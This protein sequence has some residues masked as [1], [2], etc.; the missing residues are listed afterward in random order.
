M[1]DTIKTKKQLIDE[2]KKLRRK[3]SHL[4]KLKVKDR[5]EEKA[6]SESEEKYR[7]TF[8]STGTATVIAEED[9]TLS[10][11]NSE[12]E[13]LCGYSREKIEGKKSWIEFVVKEDL[14]RMK[15]YHRQ[16]RTEEGAAPTN[17]EFRFVDRHGNIKE[18]FLT[19]A[20]IP[21]T[22][23]SVVS[24]LD[25]TERKLMEKTLNERV[26]ELNCLYGISGLTEKPD[27]S[28]EKIVQGTVDL[29]PPSWQY[30]DITC[31]RII[32]EGK[33]YTTE[34][35]RETEW[36]QTADVTTH[37]RRAGTVE[38]YYLEERP[39]SDEGPFLK[40][41][42]NLLYEIAERLG[43]IA[44]R[45]RAEGALRESEE[46]YR[47]LQANIPVGIFRTTADPEG[48]LLSV[49]PALARMFGYDN[50]EAMSETRVADLY[51]NHDDRKKFVEAVSSGG[52]ISN[53]EVQFKRNDGTP[54]WGSLNARAITDGSGKV[55]YF[56]GVL[57]DITEHKRAE[58]ALRKEKEKAQSYLDI[59]GVM[60]VVIGS[61]QK[62]SLINKRGGEILRYSEEDIVGKNWF[63]NFLPERIREDIKARFDVLMAGEKE[64]DPYFENP[65]LTKDGEERIILWH[66][67][68]LTDD[69][70]KII[71]TLSSGE[72][73][74]ERKQYF[75]DLNEYSKALE[76][77]LKERSEF[78]S[79]ASHELR[80]P[81][82][83]VNGYLDIIERNLENMDNAQ[84]HETLKKVMEHSERLTLLVETL[85]DISKIDDPK[86]TLPSELCKIEPIVKRALN[87]CE[88]QAQEKQIT[89]HF[90]GFD[91][92]GGKPCVIGDA[93]AIENVLL[94]ILGN[95]IKYSNE[96]SE[97][98][99]RCDT[100]DDTLRIDCIDQGIGL[101]PG[102]E[103]RIFEE[104]YRV[105]QG[106][107][108]KKSGHGLGLS[109]AR[110]LV[111]RM[112][113]RIWAHS[114]GLNKGTTVSFT[115]PLAKSE[116]LTEKE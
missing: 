54:F 44:E 84:I 63:D 11:V 89:C 17:Y 51:M 88:H 61:D 105:E 5:K 100:E 112:G 39:Q 77:L 52:A 23:K 95:A 109:I 96:G 82:T 47:S 38:V 59:A 69:S 50:P 104:F 65:I 101:P 79:M 30:P 114:E 115:L 36:V 4:E 34:N 64:S 103:E 102:V 56:D 27:I 68:I 32:I 97:V 99:I 41:A 13:R 43:K 1:D 19:I 14:E 6:F 26:K 15:E 25:I 94:N 98:I 110:R 67:T 71:G 76:S 18:I 53:Y 8:E 111:E 49:N 57:E 78:F 62:V 106:G 7:T 87:L 85:L 91:C 28:L 83:V 2:L 90:G 46:S 66:N 93:L 35:F 60:F 116:N 16:R 12:F 21:G 22:K 75:S 40:E 37:G 10:M 55:A 73:I 113:G 72:D 31:A 29:I 33:E 81:I 9:T 92:G 24:L 20:V 86:F 70:A 48:H 45:K 58:E 80:T 3:V 108:L 74:T 107:E 42:R